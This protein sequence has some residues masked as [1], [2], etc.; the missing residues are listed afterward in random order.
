MFSSFTNK[1][2][3][4]P[5]FIEELIE[6]TNSFN[7]QLYLYSIKQ[8]DL[9][10]QAYKDFITTNSFYYLFDLIL[11]SCYNSVIALPVVALQYHFTGATNAFLMKQFM[12][13]ESYVMQSVTSLKSE[14]LVLEYI[15]E[16]LDFREFSIEGFLKDPMYLIDWCTEADPSIS[17]LLK[18]IKDRDIRQFFVNLIY[19]ETG[20]D[21]TF[22]ANSLVELSEN[23]QVEY[24]D[25]VL[26]ATTRHVTL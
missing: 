10:I 11:L 25:Y 5:I 3:P 26:G 6:T 8:A 15:E 14:K 16:F 4:P 9:I 21:I 2:T 23:I 22:H 24:F 17:Y 18:A 1:V 7:L 19:R 20:C 13:S 12:F